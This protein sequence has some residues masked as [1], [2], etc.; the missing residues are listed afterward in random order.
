MAIELGVP[1]CCVEIYQSKA[2]KFL[3]RKINLTEHLRLSSPKLAIKEDDMKTFRVLLILTLI[4][5]SCQDHEHTTSMQPA[6]NDSVRQSNP[7]SD[8]LTEDF[9][10]F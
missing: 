4:A 1:A 8:T 3:V 9:Q 6:N 5:A 10:S 7:V 2:A